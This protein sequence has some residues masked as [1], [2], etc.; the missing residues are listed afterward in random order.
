MAAS[1]EVHVE[2]DFDSP[3]AG[4]IRSNLPFSATCIRIARD[5]YPNLRAMASAANLCDEADTSKT[6]EG[7]YGYVLEDVPHF[8]DYLPDLPVSSFISV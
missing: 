3:G 2:G 7:E 8:I 6:I 1:D 4:P 5:S